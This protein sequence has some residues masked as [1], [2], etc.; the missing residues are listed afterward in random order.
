MMGTDGMAEDVHLIV[1]AV[2]K[3]LNVFQI[4]TD[5][6]GVMLSVEMDLYWKSNAMMATM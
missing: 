2:L 5:E 1:K 6:V 4:D 3:G